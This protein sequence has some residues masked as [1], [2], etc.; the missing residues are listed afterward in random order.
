MKKD[1]LAY[2]SVCFL[3]YSICFYG[4]TL[5]AYS[6]KAEETLKK[7]FTLIK[8]RLKP[9]FQISFRP[10]R[11]DSIVFCFPVFAPVFSPPFPPIFGSLFPANFWFSLSLQFTLPV[12]GEPE[13]AAKSLEEMVRVSSDLR[14]LAQLVLAYAKFDLNKVGAI[15]TDII[16]F[17][18]IISCGDKYKVNDIFKRSFFQD[19]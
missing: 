16:S 1:N 6:R 4:F 12:L 9:R 3:L 18:H 11:G 2:H 10:F 19:A 14:T 13:V 5:F 15:S 17:F 8:Y 7:T